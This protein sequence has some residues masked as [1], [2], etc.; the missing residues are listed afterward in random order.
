MAM[1]LLG[2]TI[3][4][5]GILY[6]VY[7]TRDEAKFAEKEK[8]KQDEYNKMTEEDNQIISKKKKKI[9]I[10]REKIGEFEE[11]H[12]KNKKAAAQRIMDELYS[13]IRLK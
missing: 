7:N 8:I 13:R 10:Y 1:V 12:L 3:T 6:K 9:Q 2:S 5:S 11:K 4:V